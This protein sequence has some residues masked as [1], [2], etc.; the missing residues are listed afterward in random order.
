MDRYSFTVTDFHHLLLAG[1]AGAHPIA[2][3]SEQADARNERWSSGHPHSAS[4]H[5]IIPSVY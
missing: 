5:V 1:F 4:G 2:V 3:T